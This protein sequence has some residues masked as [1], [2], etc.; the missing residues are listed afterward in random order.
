MPVK[1]HLAENG[2]VYQVERK[3]HRSGVLVWLDGLFSGVKAAQKGTV[4]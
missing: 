1:G 2:K 4:L 3:R